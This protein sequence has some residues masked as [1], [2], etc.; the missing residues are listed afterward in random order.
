MKGPQIRN[1]LKTN[2]HFEVNNKRGLSSLQV[3]FEP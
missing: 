2:C 3:I 1:A